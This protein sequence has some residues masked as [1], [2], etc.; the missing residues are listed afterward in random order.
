MMPTETPQLAGGGPGIVVSVADEGRLSSESIRLMTIA[1]HALRAADAALN[2]AFLASRALRTGQITWN[3][4]LAYPVFETTVVYEVFKAW[5]PIASVHWEVRYE[6]GSQKQ[7]DLVVEGKSTMV[8]EFKWWLSNQAKALGC[9][10]E[11]VN[12]LREW[13]G[14]GVERILVALWWGWDW[15]Q[16][17]RDI[18]AARVE[19][20]D[21]AWLSRFPTHVRQ[22][23]DAYFALAGLSVDSLAPGRG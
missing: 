8:F 16:D 23:T 19:H 17:R 12:K 5:L 2:A 20:A 18:E 14:P 11:D 13:P 6:G 3:E 15:D 21:L 9:L 7:A 4:G 22:H 1:A 10:Q